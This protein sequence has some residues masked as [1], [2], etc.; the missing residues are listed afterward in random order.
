MEK[1][2][3]QN[4]IEKQEGEATSNISNNGPRVLGTEKK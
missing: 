1:K 4:K 3:G 2:P